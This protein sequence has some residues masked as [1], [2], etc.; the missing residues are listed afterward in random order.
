M[1]DFKQDF[2]EL[3]TDIVPPKVEELR[4]LRSNLL[5]AIANGDPLWKEFQQNIMGKKMNLASYRAH[6][7]Q[8]EDSLKNQFEYAKSLRVK[9]EEYCKTTLQQ[10]ERQRLYLGNDLLKVTKDPALKEKILN[11]VK[12]LEEIEGRLQIIKADWNAVYE[13]IKGMIEDKRNEHEYEMLEN[14]WYFKDYPGSKKDP[15]YLK[16]LKEKTD[17]EVYAES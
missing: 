1:A 5:D 3:A 15:A 16:Y 7:D 8:V 4:V 14:D 6:E 13:Y 11:E 12:T 10:I 17:A 9:F 2:K